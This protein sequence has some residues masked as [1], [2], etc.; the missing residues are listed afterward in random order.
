VPDAV[1]AAVAAA[2]SVSRVTVVVSYFASDIC[3]A[4]VR[5]QMRSYRRSSSRSSEDAT[6]AGVRNARRR[7]DR[8][9]RL[10]RVLA[11]VAVAARV[12]G[13]ALSP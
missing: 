10:L 3:E 12:G 7:A 13:T 4:T 6:D 9:V 5:F 2:A 8:L 11:L 1:N